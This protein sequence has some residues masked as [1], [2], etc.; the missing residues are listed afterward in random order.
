MG[1]EELDSLDNLDE[2]FPSEDDTALLPGKKS[3]VAV[4]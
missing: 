4:N 3:R 2:F 1:L